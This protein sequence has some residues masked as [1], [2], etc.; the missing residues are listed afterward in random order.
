ML[1]NRQ[2][3]A[4]LNMRNI[5]IDLVPEGNPIL[6]KARASSRKN[7]PQDTHTF[8]DRFS[9]S[10]QGEAKSPLACH[11][12]MFIRQLKTQGLTGSSLRQ[13]PRCGKEDSDPQSAVI[14]GYPSSRRPMQQ[15]CTR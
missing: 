10:S 13:H 4:T 8:P 6:R 1:P 14:A 12:K 3:P 9:S 15:L 2:L 7:L 5:Q 11:D